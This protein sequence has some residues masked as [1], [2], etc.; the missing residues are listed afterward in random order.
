MNGAWHLNALEW[1]TLA[2]LVTLPFLASYLKRRLVN[3]LYAIA[4]ARP[5]RTDDRR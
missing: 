2:A 5:K 3:K 1:S 4:Y